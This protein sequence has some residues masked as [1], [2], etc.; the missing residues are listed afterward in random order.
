[1]INST[2]HTQIRD[3]AQIG[4]IAHSTRDKL[5]NKY[6]FPTVRMLFLQHKKSRSSKASADLLMLWR[7]GLLTPD[8]ISGFVLFSCRMRGNF[9]IQKKTAEIPSAVFWG[10]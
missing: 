7:I 5:M 2:W 6:G 8:D 9:R 1:M 4:R 10:V 3:P